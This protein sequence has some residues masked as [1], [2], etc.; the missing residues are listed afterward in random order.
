MERIFESYR[1]PSYEKVSLTTKL[2]ITPRMTLNVYQSQQIYAGECDHE[3]RLAGTLIFST[4]HIIRLAG[5]NTF[6]K[7]TDTCFLKVF[8][9]Y[10]CS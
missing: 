8:K 3:N 1:S 4:M 7:K 6:H 9:F 10:N 2:K 5:S